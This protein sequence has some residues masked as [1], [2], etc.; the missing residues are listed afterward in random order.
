MKPRHPRAEVT[1]NEPRWLLL[2]ALDRIA[3]RWKAR[4]MRLEFEGKR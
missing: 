4:Q 1:I 2:W 3:K